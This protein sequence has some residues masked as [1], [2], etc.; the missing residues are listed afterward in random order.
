[1]KIINEGFFSTRHNKI[2][3]VENLNKIRKRLYS[4]NEWYHDININLFEIIDDISSKIIGRANYD[5]KDSPLALDNSEI[6]KFEIV[7]KFSEFR[8]STQNVLLEY[9]KD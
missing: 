7:D 8:N 6:L 4:E 1:M 5:I 9:P 2:E 3:R